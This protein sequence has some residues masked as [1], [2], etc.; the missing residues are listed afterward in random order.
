MSQG[1]FSIIIVE[2][3]MIIMGAMRLNIQDRSTTVAKREKYSV[4]GR[5][6]RLLWR[7]QLISVVSAGV[8]RNQSSFLDNGCYAVCS[9]CNFKNNSIS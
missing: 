7:E 1:N 2:Q 9:R 6:S 8:G 3:I 5:I 4:R